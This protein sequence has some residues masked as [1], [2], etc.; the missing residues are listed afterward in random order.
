MVADPYQSTVFSEARLYLREDELDRALVAF[1]RAMVALRNAATN[2]LERQKIGEADLRALQ[3]LR[4]D[5]GLSPT[6]LGQ[7][8]GVVKQSLARTIDGMVQKGLV[9]RAAGERDARERRLYLTENG[10]VVEQAV[11][12]VVRERLASAFRQA[13]PEAVLATRRVLAFI[14]DGA[15]G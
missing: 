15:Q 3:E 12:S 4:R 7:R 6:Q 5:P 11:S 9:R 13:G 1:S 8:L 14:A 10:A 2:E